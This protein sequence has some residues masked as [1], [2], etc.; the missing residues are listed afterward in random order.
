M[1]AFERLLGSTGWLTGNDAQGYVSDWLSLST[2]SPMGVARPDSVAAV[3]AVAQLAQRHQLN[4]VPQGGNTGLVLGSVPRAKDS[5]SVIVSLDRL[6]AVQHIDPVGRTV[7]VQ[8]GV[9]LDGLQEAVAEYNLMVPL[10][11]GSSGSAHIGGLVSTNAGGCHAFHAGMMADQ[12]LG[13]EAVLPDGSI[14]DGNRA[15][16]KDNAGYALKRLFCGAEGTLGIITGVTLKLTQ[17]PA[18]TYTV[19]LSCDDMD[20]A[21]KVL[22]LSQACAGPLLNSAE[23]MDITGLELLQRHC[24]AVKIPLDTLSAIT[25]LF[26]FTSP[27]EQ[28][29]LASLVEHILEQALEEEWATDGVVAT[30]EQHRRVM[31]ELRESIPEG[32]RIHGD[33][34]KHDVSVPVA[35][36]AEFIRRAS[37]ACRAV[38]SSV[39]I[40]PFGHM[41]DGNVHFNL[42]APSEESD[43]F[44]SHRAALNAAVYETTVEFNGSIAAEHGLGRAKVALADKTRPPVERALMKSV[45]TAI[46]PDGI[47]NPGVILAATDEVPDVLG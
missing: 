27:S 19:L 5:D 21:L 39:L 44:A 7:R 33:Q 26:E 22:S 36:L 12:V 9:V 32:Q 8:S 10:Q 11:L 38:M 37:E 24:P 16:V 41:A 42:S 29:P 2:A 6:N 25:V 23:F 15:L 17:R 30:T 40:N 20:H 45:K 47:M 46:D 18:D 14:W 35:S 3:A 31:W 34:L 13:L 1:Q 28:I 4:L 43:T